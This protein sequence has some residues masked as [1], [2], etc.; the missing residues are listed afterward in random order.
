MGKPLDG[1]E[2]IHYK[3]GAGAGSVGLEVQGI[4]YKVAMAVVSLL[5]ARAR[6]PAQLSLQALQSPTSPCRAHPFRYH[7]SP[8]IS[9]PGSAMDICPDVV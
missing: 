8:F 6:S 5:H 7:C 1:R 2:G 4:L 3:V 9:P